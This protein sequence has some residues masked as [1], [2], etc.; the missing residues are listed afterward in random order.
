[1]N[2]EL[3]V[4]RKMLSGNNEDA[5]ISKP[6]INIAIVGIALGLA[7][8]LMSVA[9]VTG[10]KTTIKNKVFGFGS[11]MQIINY[12]SNNS[13]ESNPI[14]QDLGF[15]DEIR[16]LPGIKHVQTYANK[17]GIIKTKKNV[18]A[19][20][21]KAVGDDY[22]W[23]F[24]QEHLVEGE[25]FQVFD[26]TKTN[27]AL[28]SKR[29]A[30][31]LELKVGEKFITSFIPKSASSSIRYRKFTISGIYQTNLEEFDKKYI[32]ADI[33]HIRRLNNWEENQISGFEIELNNYDD[34]DKIYPQVMDIIGYGFLKDGS[35][36]SLKT[37]EEINPFLFDWLGLLDMNVWVILIIITLVAVLNMTSGLL[38]IILEKT[39]MIGILKAFGTA[40]RSV[41]QVFVY[42][43]TFII[44]KGIL[45]GNIIGIAIIAMQSIFH[46]FPLDETMYFISYVPVNL[47]ISHLIVVNIGSLLITAFMLLFPSFIITK[48]SPAEAIKFE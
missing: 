40:N 9:I 14:S 43:G 28:I 23:S 39:N 42:Q 1:M 30:D 10:F 38:V 21:V 45:W 15:I 44:G 11:H 41:R 34:I 2:T 25:T 35:K 19:V 8:M 29:L 36:L 16:T 12:D 33:A 32:I 17:A 27:K 4:A 5:N 6:I 48:I 22:N 37:I 13:Y 20:L 18:Q 46:V 24:F 47:K 31:A 26:T 3:F 7:V